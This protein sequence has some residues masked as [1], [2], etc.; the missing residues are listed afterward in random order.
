[1][2]ERGDNR[3]GVYEKSEFVTIYEH[4]HMV[5]VAEVLVIS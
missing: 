2:H 3:H 1:M 5:Q 4:F